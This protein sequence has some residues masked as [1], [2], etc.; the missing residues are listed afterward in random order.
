VN[1]WNT[2]L[3]PLKS[4]SLALPAMIGCGIATMI[5]GAIAWFWSKYLV[6]WILFLV[7]VGVICLVIFMVTPK[8]GD[9]DEKL[10]DP[11]QGYRFPAWLIVLT[12]AALYL[13]VHLVVIWI[14]SR[15]GAKGDGS[16]EPARFPDQESAWDEI[17]IRLS[18]ARYDAGQQKVFLLLSTAESVTASLIRSAG[19]QFFAQAPVD[20]NAPIHA[21]ATA[22]GLF[23]SCA[24]ASSWG[25]G[26]DEGT[27][28]LIDLCRKLLALN[29]EQPVLRGLAVV[30]PMERAASA[31]LLQGIGALRNDFQTIRGELNV[32]CPTFAVFCQHEPYAGFDEFAARIPPD[33]R[34]RRCGFSVPL[35]QPFDR[36]AMRKGLGWLVQWFST[37]SI[38]LMTDDYH[39]KESNSRLVL[40][41][42][43]LWRD[44]PA[45]CHLLDVSFSTHARAEPILVRGCYF[46]ACAPDP[47]S[48]AFA[49]GLVN[50]KTSKMI[51]DAGYTS[52][53]RDAGAIDRR[54][55]LAA[56]G[57]AL[58]A[59][60][61][62]LSIW[63]YGV[64]RRI[65]S[66]P[67]DPHAGLWLA[68]A[69]LG[70]LALT[71]AAGLLYHWYGRK[72][73]AQSA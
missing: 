18:N 9:L 59:A 31:E 22:D 69:C 60:A 72:V 2:L 6:R 5:T 48:Q 51:A 29:P 32:R 30:Y 37:W 67:E 13:S 46:V 52:W 25:R 47:D 68:W 17:Q 16:G 10:P 65:L 40:M 27:A 4:Q 34:A 7:T 39:D 70:A 14:R 66:L 71:W 54:Y 12:L 11:F 62:S 24:G 35:A 56:L 73:I 58:C 1:F 50:G 61:I 3:D 42:A 55:H 21:Y 43:Q 26:D 41:N 64:I 33:V 57:L 63:Y 23:I 15:S 20:E 19:L 45:L 28:R 53:S 49:T 44:L 36:V 38:K 8:I